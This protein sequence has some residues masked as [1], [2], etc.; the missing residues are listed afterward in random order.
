MKLYEI[1]NEMVDLLNQV[2]VETG[3]LPEQLAVITRDFSGKSANVVAYILNVT[4]EIEKR[5]E[6][7]KKLNEK[8]KT[9]ENR[10]SKLKDYLQYH[11]SR[12]GVTK[13]EANDLSFTAKLLRERDETV[14]VYDERLLAKE[15]L[16]NIPER[17]E[18]DKISIRKALKAGHEVQGA[19]LVRKDRLEIK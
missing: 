11:M 15:Y 16:R 7:I 8:V 17:F 5:K 12:T 13:I 14:E 3:E 1:S 4:A 10:I 9:D 6:L 18:A 19:R 2:D